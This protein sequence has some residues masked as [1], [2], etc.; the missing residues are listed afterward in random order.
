MDERKKNE[1]EKRKKDSWKRR[2]REKR[3]QK[4]RLPRTYSTLCSRC[5]LVV[6]DLGIILGSIPIF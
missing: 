4:K 1:R 5:P 2:R 6:R 3:N